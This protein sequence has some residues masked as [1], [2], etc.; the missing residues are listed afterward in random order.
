VATAKKSAATRATRK[1][2]TEN[3]LDAMTR[4]SVERKRIEERSVEGV[5]L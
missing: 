2:L 5:V 4:E 1:E 3:A